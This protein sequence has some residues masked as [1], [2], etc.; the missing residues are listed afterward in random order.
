MTFYGFSDP[1]KDRIFEH[2]LRAN[3]NK[4]GY[5]QNGYPP[6]SPL[7]L[8]WEKLYYEWKSTCTVGCVLCPHHSQCHQQN[9]R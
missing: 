1:I 6:T 9:A 7:A 8:R 2:N 3:L 5:S 4:S